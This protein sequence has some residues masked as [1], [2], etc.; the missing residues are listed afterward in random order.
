MMIHEDMSA[1]SDDAGEP[2]YHCDIC[3]N[4]FG[5][6]DFESGEVI[7]NPDFAAGHDPRVNRSDRHCSMVYMLTGT[8]TE[9]DAWWCGHGCFHHDEGSEPEI[10]TRG[11]RV[12]VCGKCGAR[13]S[14]D[15]YDDVED[16]EQEAIACC[17]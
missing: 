1:R 2:Y 6:D 7:Y 13:Y 14:S 5:A 3:D 8:G 16:A 9:E 11:I 17:K 15:D 12:F 10:K 4:E